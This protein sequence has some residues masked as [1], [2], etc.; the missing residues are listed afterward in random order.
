MIE[1]QIISFIH[2]FAFTDMDAAE[3]LHLYFDQ[4][5][6]QYW[7]PTISNKKLINSH[8]KIEMMSLMH[9]ETPGQS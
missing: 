8:L 1:S 9:M 3:L 2:I 6:T 7:M 5:L 4:H